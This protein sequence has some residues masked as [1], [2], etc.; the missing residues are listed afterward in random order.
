VTGTNLLPCSVVQW[1]NPSPSSVTSP[2]TTTYVSATQLSATI[3][4]ADFLAMGTAQ[5]EVLTIGPGG[6]HIRRAPIHNS[7]ADHHFLV[8]LYDFVE[9]N[10][11]V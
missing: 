7:S 2:L 10:A 8:V 11:V 1:V 6:R 3:P 9:H 5:I 4:A